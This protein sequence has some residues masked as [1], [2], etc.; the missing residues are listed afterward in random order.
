MIKS[1]YDNQKDILDAIEKL[2]CPNGFHCDL[3]YGNGQFYKDRTKP[4]FRFDKDTSLTDVSHASSEAVPLP[5]EVV[6]NIMFDP[7]FLCYVKKERNHNSIMAKRFSGYWHYKEL[8]THYKN[9]I[10]E[11]YRLLKPNGVLVIKCQDIIHNHQLYMTHTNV[12]NWCHA[13]KLRPLDLFVLVAKARI[14]VK[15]T[16]AQQHARIFHSYFMVFKKDFKLKGLSK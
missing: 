5:D 12:A 7:P 14:P 9:T 10:K 8:E 4:I 6:E 13:E 15:S 3:T 1:T 2:H 11:C 16:G